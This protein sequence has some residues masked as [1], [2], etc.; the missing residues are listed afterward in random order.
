MGLETNTDVDDIDGVQDRNG[1]VR[2][3]AN[4]DKQ[5]RVIQAVENQDSLSAG[6]YSTSSTNVEQLPSQSIP[7]GV[8]VA[9]QAKNGNTGAVFVGTSN[10]TPIRLSPNS[11]VSLAVT[12]LSLVHIQTPN[13]GDGIGYIFEG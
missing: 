7:D 11:N 2:P 10:E 3:A 13:S 12:D 5:D 1:D 4:A 8:E 6:S 9:I